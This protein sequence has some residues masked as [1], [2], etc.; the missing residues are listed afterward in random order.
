MAEHLPAM[1]EALVPSLALQSKTD[2]CLMLEKLNEKKI[3]NR[4][5]K[6]LCVVIYL[7]SIK[8]LTLMY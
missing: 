8:K 1:R 7:H 3:I 4:C 2:A 5:V 6:Q